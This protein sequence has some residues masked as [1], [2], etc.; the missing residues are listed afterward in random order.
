[1][2]FSFSGGV[3]YY[4]TKVFSTFRFEAGSSFIQWKQEAEGG[5]IGIQGGLG[6][7][8]RLTQN[9][10]FL[11]EAQGRYAKIGGFQGNGETSVSGGGS[12]KEEGTLW[13]W[14]EVSAPSGKEYALIFINHE[15]PTGAEIRSVREAQIDLTGGSLIAGIMIRL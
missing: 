11:I 2:N 3:G 8:I 4:L 14:K 7:E 9:F 5:K 15:K 6:L 13:F 1:L 12:I 10:S